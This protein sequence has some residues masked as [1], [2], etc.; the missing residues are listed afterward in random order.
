[1]IVVVFVFWML[2]GLEL[3]VLLLGLSS[4]LVH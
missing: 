3:I 1:M 2:E 4:F